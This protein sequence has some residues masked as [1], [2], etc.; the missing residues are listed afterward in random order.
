MALAALGCVGGDLEQP[1]EVAVMHADRARQR[2]FVA[3]M[4][5]QPGFGFDRGDDFGQARPQRRVG[6][7][8]PQRGRDEAA[9]ILEWD[10]VDRAVESPRR[11]GRAA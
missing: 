6:A 9:D 3:F 4:H 5:E 1:G 8:A 11:R 10:L 2:P 7:A